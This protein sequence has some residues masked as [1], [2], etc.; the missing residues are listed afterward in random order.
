MAAKVL[1]AEDDNNLREIYQA[2]LMA[3]GYEVT[4]AQNGEEA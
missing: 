4:A 1:L 3:E 2:R